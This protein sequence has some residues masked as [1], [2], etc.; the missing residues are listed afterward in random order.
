MVHSTSH[1][2]EGLGGTVGGRS[3]NSASAEPGPSPRSLRSLL[4]DE[5]A[6]AYDPEPNCSRRYERRAGI[7]R[8]SAAPSSQSGVQI[9]GGNDVTDA[10]ALRQARQLEHGLIIDPRHPLAGTGFGRGTV[11]DPITEMLFE[12]TGKAY[13]ATTLGV[14]AGPLARGALAVDAATAAGG[15]AASRGLISTQGFRFFF[16][17][18]GILNSN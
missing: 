11:E 18:S 7:S 1:R 4:Y 9:A 12:E 2:G 8:T 3:R 5:F 16:G 13:V 14:V 15:G 10:E 17:R 6:R